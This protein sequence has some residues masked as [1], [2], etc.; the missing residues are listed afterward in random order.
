M[1]E[2]QIDL[3][4]K[5]LKA[6]LP[7]IINY[8]YSKILA[9]MTKEIN[10]IFSRRPRMPEWIRV[11]THTGNCREDI[12]HILKNHKLNT[13]CKSAKCPNLGECWHKGTATFMLLGNICTRNCRFCAIN[14]GLPNP[15]DSAEPENVAKAVK[16][17][18]L[19][20]VVITS[21]T[22]DDLPNGGASVFA[23]TIR[24]IREINSDAIKIE[25]LTPDFNCDLNS[26]KMVLGAKPTV[27]NHNIETIKRLTKEV[28]A[29]ATYENSLFV[30][31]QAFELSTGELPIKSGL[32]VG[33]GE[34][35]TEVEEC[36]T[37]IRSTGATMLTIGQYL[38]PTPRNWPLDRYVHPSQFDLW[39][40]FALKIGF[41]NVAS[42]PL[43]RSS[44]CAEDL[45]HS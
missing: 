44:Y 38:P 21:V 22:R 27:F 39:K 13:V 1:K 8:E 5:S 28:R 10:S 26:L 41:N 29:K 4:F 17:M 18:Q 23:E 20:Y 19:K 40:V 25:V 45:T 24:K 43:V 16:E 7:F 42:A 15:I 6:N 14:T 33:L 36:I 32:M 9:L 12:S 34:T 37:D 11:K 35:D 2:P 31:R 30:L 3:L